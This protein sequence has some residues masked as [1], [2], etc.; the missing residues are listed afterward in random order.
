MISFG[1]EVNVVYTIIV[2]A[3]AF[4]VLRLVRRFLIQK[5]IK[6]GEIELEV[7]YERGVK[8][9]I[10]VVL[11]VLLIK[12]WGVNLSSL[13]LAG[14]ILTLAI[15]LAAQTLISN[16]LTGLFILSERPLKPGDQIEIPSEGI[17]GVVQELTTL[18]TKVRLWTG[19]TARI[20]NVYLVEKIVK[21]LSRPKARRVDIRVSV[22]VNDVEK[23]LDVI[24]SIVEEDELILAE[25]APEVYL[26]EIKDGNAKI[27]VK[28]WTF[29]KTWYMIT[30]RLPY[31]ILKK[32]KESGI[33]PA[34]PKIEVRM[35][36]GAS[37]ER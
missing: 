16:L 14:G 19:E 31:E 22:N 24:R 17:S 3:L 37:P 25:P 29:N 13:I 12:I 18:S 9:L 7:M 32:L 10:A 15:S 8:Y 30:T 4:I 26:E 27:V 21:N 11:I 34:Y 35:M 33:M 23:A 2:L 36:N 28:V 5:I 6:R 1:I 20:P